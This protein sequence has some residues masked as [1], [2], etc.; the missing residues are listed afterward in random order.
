VAAAVAAWLR[1]LGAWSRGGCRACGRPVAKAFEVPLKTLPAALFPGEVEVADEEMDVMAPIEDMR[2]AGELAATI[3]GGAE[4]AVT[5]GG[6]AAATVAAAWGQ[7]P[8]VSHTQVQQL[9]PVMG[10]VMPPVMGHMMPPQV[11]GQMVPQVVGQVMPQVVLGAGHA[12]TTSRF[13]SMELV[14][15]EPPGAELL[16]T[17]QLPEAAPPECSKLEVVAS[18]GQVTVEALPQQAQQAQQFHSQLQCQQVPR[19]LKAAPQRPVLV[20]HC[21]HPHGLFSMFSLALGQAYLCEQNSLCLIVD[22]SSEELLYRGPP[23]EPNLW[24]VFFKQPA[25]LVMEHEVLLRTLRQGAFYESSKSTVA[26]GAYKGVIQGYGSIPQEL[27]SYGR[28]LCR[29]TLALRESFADR[30]RSAAER[31]LG[32]GHRWLAVHIRRGDKACES[33]ANFELSDDD[34]VVRISAQAV[35]WRCGGVF[36]CSDDAALK[37]RLTERLST[38]VV[39]GGSG[40]VVSSY[41]ATLPAVQGQAAHFDKSLDSYQKAEDV[42]MEALLMSRGCHGLLSTL[43]NV[44]AMSVFISPEGFPYTTFFDSLES[45]VAALNG[46]ASEM[47]SDPLATYTLG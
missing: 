28:A 6:E 38:A 47:Q 42:V 19:P 40:L 1:A 7:L 16:H 33:K 22:W 43:S 24:T 20:W 31:F 45:T 18:S 29:R 23:H 15:S 21:K 37:K 10:P 17:A 13:Q 44:S 2:L 27:A 26:F 25:E 41:P 30:V 11:V 39:D 12:P 9:P 14:S 5:A 46:A 36:L 34:L 35:M 4:E 8:Q 3:E 32:G